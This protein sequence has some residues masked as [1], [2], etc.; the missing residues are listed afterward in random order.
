MIIDRFQQIGRHE[1][2]QHA[3]H[4]QRREHGQRGGPA[5]LLEKASDHAAHE[6]RRQEYRDQCKGGGNHR[7][8]D[9][10]GGFHCGLIGRLAHAQVADDVLDLDNGIIDQN[11]DHQRQGQQRDDIQRE[12]EGVHADES[13]NGRQRQRDGG[14]EGRP[15]VTQEQP[16]HQHRQRGTLVQQRH[17]CVKFL[18]H[19]LDEIERLGED[20]I[21]SRFPHLGQYLAH[22]RPDLHFAGAPAAADFETN[23]RPAIQQGLHAWLGHGVDHP[24]NLF[25]ADAPAAGNGKL[26]RSQFLGRSHRGQGAH[27]L[28]TAA[29]TGPPAGAFALHIAQLVGNLGGGRAQRLQLDRVQLDGDFAAGPAH[30]GDRADT[31]HRQQSL[32]EC[33]IDEP[34]QRFVVPPIGGQR[35]G[36]YRRLDQIQ[37]ADDRVAHVAGEVGAD[38]GDGRA[39]IVQRLLHRLL[40]AKLQRQVDAAVLNLGGDVLEPLQGSHGI[41]QLAGHLGL[42]LGRRGAGL[43]GA[44]R[45]GRQVQ[46]RK[47]LHLHRLEA[48]QATEGQQHKQHDCRQGRTNAG[49]GDVH[50]TTRT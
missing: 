2:R 24:G 37:L 48:H 9:L 10:V 13:R 14:D 5:E 34:R 39:G 6:S 49:R 35:I 46:I 22:G 33:V 23:H 17:R 26:Q 40:Q 18:F 1:R 28:F 15:P 47:V 8:A 36:E 20:Q 19:R 16:H 4:H 44:D 11:A 38:F 3:R 45:D 31:R 43:A 29:D 7:E 21:R 41:L 50:C 25:Q 30:A 42:Q 32:G 27:W 12:T